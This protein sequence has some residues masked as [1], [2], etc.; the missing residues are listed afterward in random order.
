MFLNHSMT[1]AE[2][3]HWFKTV[4][5]RMLVFILSTIDLLTTPI[6]IYIYGVCRVISL[7]DFDLKTDIMIL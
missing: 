4:W 2:F 5:L 3:L 1:D 6:S 7:F